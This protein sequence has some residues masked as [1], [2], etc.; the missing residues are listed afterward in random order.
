MGPKRTP[1]TVLLAK[2]SEPQGACVVWIGKK[3]SH[4]YGRVW[5]SAQ[6]RL[7]QAHRAAYVQ[8]I[9]LIPDGLQ[10]DH[11]CNNRPCVNPAHLEP[12]TPFEN[13]AR[14]RA[15]ASEYNPRTHCRN[16]HAY[17]EAN[18]YY[19]GNYRRCRACNADAQR[20]RKAHRKELA[21]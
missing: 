20:R 2:Y 12:V 16:G 1:I 8:A 19:A 5:D 17:D 9:G 14:A 21:R 6:Q 13:S 11:L 4:G 7:V 10:L 15:R 3:D 18:T